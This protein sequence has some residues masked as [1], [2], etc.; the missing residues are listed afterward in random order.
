[1]VR[2]EGKGVRKKNSLKN[3]KDDSNQIKENAVDA[4]CK[5]GEARVG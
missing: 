2:W 1:L 5:K 3:S 4:I